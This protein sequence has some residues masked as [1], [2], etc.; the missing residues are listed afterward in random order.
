MVSRMTQRRFHVVHIWTCVRTHEIQP[1]TLTKS[2]LVSPHNSWTCSFKHADAHGGLGCTDAWVLISTCKKFVWST[3]IGRSVTIWIL[4]LKCLCSRFQ[5]VVVKTHS[6]VNSWSSRSPSSEQPL[7]ACL[8]YSPVTF[9]KHLIRVPVTPRFMVY[10]IVSAWYL[11]HKVYL[12]SPTLPFF[13]SPVNELTYVET[14][15]L[16]YN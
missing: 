5:L 8:L 6:D 3:R 11:N 15:G 16:S 7:L 14:R 2:F 10:G 12:N 1:N 13:N 9:T 4:K